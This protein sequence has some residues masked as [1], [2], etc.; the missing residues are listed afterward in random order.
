MNESDSP[1]KPYE[2]IGTTGGVP[3]SVGPHRPGRWDLGIWL[4]ACV[5]LI[6]IGFWWFGSDDTEAD[7][8]PSAVH[9]S[10]TGTKSEGLVLGN[11]KPRHTAGGP[12]MAAQPHAGPVVP[13]VQPKVKVPKAKAS[14]LVSPVES[15]IAKWMATASKRSGKKVTSKNTVV[16]VHVRDLSGKVLVD[17]NTQRSL[18][19]ASNLKLLT[20]MAAV[21]LCGDGGGFFETRF[22]RKGRVEAG[23]LRGDLVARAGGDPMFDGESDGAVTRWTKDLAAQLKAQ[24]IHKVEGALILDEGTYLEPG[25][26]PSWPDSKEYWK[27]YCALSGGFSANAGSLTALIQPGKVGGP[28]RVQV[29]PKGHG[30]ERKGKVETVAKRKKLVIAV[31][32]KGN[33]L[34]VRGR[35]PADVKVYDPR[36]SHPDPVELFGHAMIQGLADQGISVT[37]GIKRQRDVSGGETVA[38]LRTPLTETFGPILR[39]SNNG[40]ADQLFFRLGHLM[41]KV[42]DRKAGANAIATVMQIMGVD[43]GDM[44]IV[45][46][47]GLSKSNSVRADQFTAVLAGLMDRGG[48]AAEAFLEALPVSGKSGTLRRRMRTGPAAGRVMAKTGFVNGTSALSG[49]VK[50]ETGEWLVFSILVSYPHQSGMNTGVFKPMQD[51]LCALLAQYEGSAQ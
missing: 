24:G 33:R 29:F 17:R 25:P 38:T 18:R 8:A 26:G 50:T 49:V 36:F 43:R 30:L 23:V 13:P 12:E 10:E 22:D 3:G 45:D 14:A 31:E 2:R 39:D 21:V 34:T 20:C 37:G 6:L 42:G 19:P 32:A 1:F 9:A 28:G 46:G 48:P 5:A 41:T 40:V 7:K 27:E 51:E 47:S 4:G 16:A 44:K 15:I 35:I 11:P